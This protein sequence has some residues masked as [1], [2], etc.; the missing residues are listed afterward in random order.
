[1]LLTIP[2]PDAASALVAGT[3]GPSLPGK[4]PAWLGAGVLEPELCP[5][6]VDDEYKESTVLRPGRRTTEER[7]KLKGELTPKR[8][9]AENALAV[10][11]EDL[12]DSPIDEGGA[13]G[14]R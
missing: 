3:L 4:K 10:V 2:A 8:F 1:M 11:L 14:A 12:T 9:R 13:D 5:V 7:C 6:P